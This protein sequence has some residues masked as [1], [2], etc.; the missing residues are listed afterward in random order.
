MRRHRRLVARAYANAAYRYRSGWGPLERS[1]YSHF[2]GQSVVLHGSVLK[3]IAGEQPPT[4][5]EQAYA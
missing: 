3:W 2:E 1:R 5:T 4:A